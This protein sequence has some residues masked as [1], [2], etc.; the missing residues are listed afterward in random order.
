MP[1]PSTKAIRY[2][3]SAMIATYFSALPI[4]PV[5]Y[6]RAH[7]DDRLAEMSTYCFAACQRR[8]HAVLIDHYSAS[9]ASVAIAP[10]NGM[11]RLYSAGYRAKNIC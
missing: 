1:P 9:R 4:T 6:F 11:H 10:V 2:A 5:N 7:D 3:A 8:Y